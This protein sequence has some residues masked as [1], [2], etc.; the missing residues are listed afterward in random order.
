MKY[1]LF[2][3]LALPFLFS[4]CEV[5]DLRSDAKP[6]KHDAWTALLQKHVDKE[7]Q[8]NYSGF[9][10]DSLAFNAYLSL[11]EKNHPDPKSWTK[12]E[13][14]A[15]WINAYN[16][17]TVK[18]ITKH[19]PVQSIKDI[20]RGIVFVST[21]WDI[22]FINI[23]TANY[24]LNNIEHGIIR[25]KFSDP[26]IHFAVN[27]ASV[28]CPALRN[29]AFEANTLDQ[30]ME[31]QSRRFLSDA[32]KNK[33]TPTEIKISKIFTWFGGDFKKGG[34]KGV[35]DFISKHST[36]NLNPAVKK[37]YLDYDWGLNH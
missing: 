33:I 31:E 8:V 20:K 18:L 3:L 26:R 23:G 4:S 28:S 15:Y 21:V 24:S 13:Q 12:D 16:A 30:Q 29:E 7:G 27:C 19:Y 2:F 17:Y 37:S 34:Y 9:I 1:T 36:V 25:K 6:I 5:K 32:A 22:N 35:V 11:L 14:L 10:E